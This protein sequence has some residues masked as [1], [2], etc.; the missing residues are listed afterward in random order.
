MKLALLFLCHC[1]RVGGAWG[2]CNCTLHNCIPAE[3]NTYNS[4]L[5][6]VKAVVHPLTITG[7]MS[8]LIPYS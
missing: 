2:E 7:F 1:F 4:F 8:I 5:G 3:Q 6:L